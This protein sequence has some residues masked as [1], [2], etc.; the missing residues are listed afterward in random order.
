MLCG[1]GLC[2]RMQR[3]YNRNDAVTV[4]RFVVVFVFVASLSLSAVAVSAKHSLI[5]NYDHFCAVNSP[6]TRD[7]NF[8]RRFLFPL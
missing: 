6:A 2:P 8:S 3:I 7:L 1:D 4:L 5:Q